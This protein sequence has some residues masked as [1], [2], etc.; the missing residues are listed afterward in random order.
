MVFAV[1]SM[2]WL[3]ALHLAVRH[4]R[5]R[6]RVVHRPAPRGSSIAYAMRHPGGRR[7]AVIASGGRLSVPTAPATVDP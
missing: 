6:G 2:G 1:A 4:W 3:Y 5:G 7:R